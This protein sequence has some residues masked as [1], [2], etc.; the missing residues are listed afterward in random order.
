MDRWKAGFPLIYV[1]KPN[2]LSNFRN[3]QQHL[4]SNVGHHLNQSPISSSILSELNLKS[5]IRTTD[6]SLVEILPNIARLALYAQGTP[7]I[8]PTNNQNIISSKDVLNNHKD[9][10]QRWPTTIS[11]LHSSSSSSSTTSS[12]ASSPNSLSEKSL[13]NSNLIQN[14]NNKNSDCLS[15]T[16]EESSSGT[17][18]HSL[19]LPRVIKP[20]KKRKKDKKTA[21]T[22]TT[23]TT[24]TSSNSNLVL[25]TI[26]EHDKSKSKDQL[27]LDLIDL[28]LLH[29]YYYRR[30]CKWEN[31][32]LFLFLSYFFPFY[33]LSILTT[34]L[35]IK[36]DCDH[37]ILIIH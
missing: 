10:I 2:Y 19:S 8:L 37:I 20:R 28:A 32:L 18:E 6:E 23:T 24:T 33:F 25:T 31:Y 11:S 16:S 1:V 14:T 29:A 13:F 27:S 3:G 26:K 21:T 30:F 15:I 17:S 4:N 7:L 35:L 34:E 9:V 36:Y 5:A 22:T 12:A